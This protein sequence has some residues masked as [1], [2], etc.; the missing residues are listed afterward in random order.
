[1]GPIIGG[2]ILTYLSFTVL[3]VIV[4]ILLFASTIPLFFSADI[5]E[6]SPFSLKFIFSRKHLK[7][8]LVYSAMGIEMMA[9][10]V[11]WPLFIFIIMNSYIKLGIV[12]TI[13]V[14]F[15]GVFAVYVGR[16]ADVHG[17]RKVLRVGAIG[18]IVFWFI[19]GF[20]NT[21]KGVFGV[22]TAAA[23]F[24]LGLLSLDAE[25]YNRANRAG[26]KRVE[27]L[28]MREIFICFG[29]ILILGVMMFLFSLIGEKSFVGGFVLTGLA[30]LL[31]LLF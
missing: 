9:N 29:R 8:A 24:S 23:F 14:A 13:A 6:P 11:L 18:D 21:V 16:F 20:V 30:E 25:A 27:Y 3:F 19:R 7:D 12:S 10:G 2:L 26:R 5:H 31:Y 1:L 17:N 28:V 15:T 4:S 22:T